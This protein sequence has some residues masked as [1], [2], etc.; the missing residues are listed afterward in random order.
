MAEAQD[1]TEQTG[2]RP[3]HQDG[4][5]PAVPQSFEG[6]LA[7]AGR[8]AGSVMSQTQQK[9][10]RQ[11]VKRAKLIAA[12]GLPRFNPRNG[13]EFED[14]V[15]IAAIKASGSATCLRVFQ[16]AWASASD[17]NLSRTVFSF[18][19]QPES[20]KEDLVD[21]VALGGLVRDTLPIITSLG[22]KSHPGLE[23]PTAWLLVERL[24]IELDLFR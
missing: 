1:L 6:V 3:G 24:T 5:L 13:G 20:T 11:L 18:K 16:E 9:S 22:N 15:D 4:E 21:H 7:L 12:L 14:W 2:G 23:R 19:I 8:A 10:V 17:H